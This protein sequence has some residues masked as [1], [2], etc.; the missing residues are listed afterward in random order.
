LDPSGDRF[1]EYTTLALKPS[2]GKSFDIG[3]FRKE[4][5]NLTFRRVPNPFTASKPTPSVVA[6]APMPHK[7]RIPYYLFIEAESAFWL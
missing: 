6:L 1:A 4:Y 2:I 5:P 3:I 7:S